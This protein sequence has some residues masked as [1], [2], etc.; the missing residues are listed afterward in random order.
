MPNFHVDKYVLRL[1]NQ[2]E[3]SSSL[4]NI[5]LADEMNSSKLWSNLKC[6]KY[7]L[8]RGLNLMEQQ[9][10]QRHYYDTV[11]ASPDTWLVLY[12]QEIKPSVIPIFVAPA[13]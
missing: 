7:V 12:N 1:C 8:S 5:K 9:W 13:K 4:H 11:K 6:A 3:R 2:G 10:K